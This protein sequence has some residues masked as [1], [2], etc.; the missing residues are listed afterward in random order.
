[1]SVVVNLRTKKIAYANLY[2]P[3]PL[4]SKPPH[5]STST[6]QLARHDIC[7]VFGNNSEDD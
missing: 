6:Y 7:F 5:L 2:K 4:V 3:K 1:M